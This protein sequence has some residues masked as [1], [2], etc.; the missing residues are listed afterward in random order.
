MAV[1]TEFPDRA[2]LPW[3]FQQLPTDWY[4]HL[5]GQLKLNSTAA[6]EA[7]RLYVESLATKHDLATLEDWYRV[8]ADQ[9]GASSDHVNR[10]GGITH[11]LKVVYP[12]YKWDDSKFANNAK[13]AAQR[14]LTVGFAKLFPGQSMSDVTSMV[15]KAKY[16]TYSQTMRKMQRWIFYR[17]NLRRLMDL[18]NTLR[19][20][21]ND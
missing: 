19:P 20:L 14:V 12:D 8:S 13:K 3:S 4:T 17:T 18:P 21:L 1:M 6:A 9:L 5:N 15:P 2:W 10:L 16:T 7:L 11:I